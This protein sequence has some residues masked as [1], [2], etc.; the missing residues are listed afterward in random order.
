MLDGNQG[1]RHLVLLL[2]DG[3]VNKYQREIK[4]GVFVDVYDVIVAFGV[5]N[6]GIQHAIKK[7][8]CAGSRGH[9]DERTDYE[10]AYVAIFRA[11]ELC[12]SARRCNWIRKDSKWH[13]EC[14]GS[15]EFNFPVDEKCPS[16]GIKI[17]ITDGTRT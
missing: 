17:R 8:L 13:P 7:L 11:I 6:P 10:E 2:W 12:E 16:C 1:R 9:K 15:N 4:P 3:T 5:S 14:C